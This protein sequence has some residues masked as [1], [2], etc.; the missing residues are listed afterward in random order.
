LDALQAATNTSFG[1]VEE[2]EWDSFNNRWLLVEDL[3]G[4]NSPSRITTLNADG[5]SGYGV[6]YSGGFAIRDIEVVP[7]PATAAV[8]GLG[9][10]LAARRRR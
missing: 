6:L 1:S 9:G 4:L 3:G 5:I 2:I 10:M 8:L 7:T